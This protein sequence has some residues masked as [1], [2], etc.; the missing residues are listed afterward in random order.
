MKPELKRKSLHIIAAA[1]PVI[2]MYMPWKVAFIF[3]IG[4][5]ILNLLIDIFRNKPTYFGRVYQYFFAGILRDHEKKGALT[6]STY[7]FLS[8]TLSYIVF[9]ILLSVPVFI[10]TIIYT[11]FMVGDA[12]AALIGKR[13]GQIKIVNN[14]TLAGSSAF[15][16]ASF[17][18]T[19]WIMLD[20]LHLVL[21]AS[22]ILTI[23]EL[24]IIK[25]DDNFFVPLI[26]FT[27][28]YFFLFG[29]G[30]SLVS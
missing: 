21:V 9:C 8:L 5:A 7:F 17:G 25:L 27:L 20:K 28:F 11:G 14:K 12:A 4:I 22:L 3:L 2:L 26:T 30:N 19:F 6:G 13:F 15:C 1:I 29:P 23:I 16:I 24:L 18:S 10:L